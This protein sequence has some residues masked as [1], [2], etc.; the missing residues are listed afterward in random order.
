[1]D[2]KKKNT[3]EIKLP[4]I[5]YGHYQGQEM[6]AIHHNFELVLWGLDQGEDIAGSTDGSSVR[7]SVKMTTALLL[8]PDGYNTMLGYGTPRHSENSS[9]MIDFRDTMKLFFLDQIQLKSWLSNQ[10]PFLSLKHQ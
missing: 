4:S 7:R 1:M 2:S 6:K 9:F 8:D 5:S 10:A 3:K